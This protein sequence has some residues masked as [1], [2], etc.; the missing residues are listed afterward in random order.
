MNLA[1]AHGD[2]QHV[3]GTVSNV[4]D[5]AITVT[6]TNGKSVDVT[7]T[8]QSTFIKD[9]KTITAKDIKLGD[10]VVIHAKKNGDKLEAAS[11]QI[12]SAKAVNQ[13]HMH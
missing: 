1:F 6:T 12:G 5:S 7:L 9:G 4:T 13:M 8:S 2:E 11:V 3:M 10:R